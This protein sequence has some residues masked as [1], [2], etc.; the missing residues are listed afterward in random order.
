MPAWEGTGIRRRAATSAAGQAAKEIG[1]VPAQ[2]AAQ[3]AQHNRAQRRS[4]Y[5][6][7]KPLQPNALRPQVGEALGTK[8]VA[9][10]ESCWNIPGP[11]L[12]QLN[13]SCHIPELFSCAG[14]A[15]S[16]QGSCCCPCSKQAAK[17]CNNSS[18][19]GHRT[20]SAIHASLEVK[21]LGCWR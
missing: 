4:G 2:S 13:P 16:L 5:D 17:Y 3:Q 15:V 20:S 14:V 18:H 11:I 1:H 12:D 8:K 6:A 21:A 10:F 7:A 19:I 9:H